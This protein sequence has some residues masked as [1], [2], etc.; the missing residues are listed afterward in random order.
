MST[1]KLLRHISDPIDEN[2]D[3]NR[4]IDP[5]DRLVGSPF[6]EDRDSVS[7]TFGEPL[8]RTSTA[9]ISTTS[10]LA[11]VGSNICPIESLDYEYVLSFL[12]HH[13]FL[14]ISL[15]WVWD[16]AIHG[17]IFFFLWVF[18]IT[19]ILFSIIQLLFVFI[20][21]GFFFFLFSSACFFVLF[22]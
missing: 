22:L 17:V 13:W 21:I 6:T 1:A 4:E 15:L 20:P 12:L 5:S 19:C 16:H 7:L 14:F 2:H 8:L 3:N 18:F 11:I 10:Q 9:R